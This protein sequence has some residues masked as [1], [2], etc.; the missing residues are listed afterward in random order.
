MAWG[1]SSTG[2]PFPNQF[3]PGPGREVPREGGVVGVDV[4]VPHTPWG[5]FLFPTE[6]GEG[7]NPCRACKV[8]CRGLEIEDGPGQE[9][10]S[11]QTALG[12]SPGPGTLA[13]VVKEG[14]TKPAPAPHSPAEWALSW[15]PRKAPGQHA[16]GR[17]R[18]GLG[19]MALG[20]S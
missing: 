18:E 5:A 3:L 8:G 15:V 14:K 10:T 9:D 17:L 13:E 7:Q 20:E 1:P 19:A 6:G 4:R 16:V 2:R 12:P 11:G